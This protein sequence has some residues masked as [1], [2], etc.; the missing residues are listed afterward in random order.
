MHHAWFLAL[1][2]SRTLH[3]SPLSLFHSAGSLCQCS[4]D[5]SVGGSHFLRC[6]YV[7][8]AS[9]K[10]QIHTAS[11]G[12]ACV[13]GLSCDTGS[14]RW[15]KDKLACNSC[16]I[17]RMLSCMHHNSKTHSKWLIATS[18]FVT[19]VN[20]L[21]CH[22]LLHFTQQPEPMKRSHSL[23]LLYCHKYSNK[24]AH[25]LHCWV[26]MPS[27]LPADRTCSRVPALPIQA[28]AAERSG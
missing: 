17:K 4:D 5:P 6:V 20:K 21:V 14:S 25:W 12:T 13:L 2:T 19:F 7:S 22:L 24:A 11:G 27:R 1:I 10:L 15:A 26:R 16:F 8:T 23:A 9:C 18:S 28:L 3:L